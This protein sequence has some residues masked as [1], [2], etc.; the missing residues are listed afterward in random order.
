M[1]GCSSDPAPAS[2]G[3]GSSP[4]SVELLT[5]SATPAGTVVYS[6]GVYLLDGATTNAAQVTADRLVFPASTGAAIAG[7]SAGDILVSSKDGHA[8]FLRRVTSV[9]TSG[10]T[11]V[12]FTQDARI[13]DAVREAHLHFVLTAPGGPSARSSPAIS[14]ASGPTGG[15]FGGKIDFAFAEGWDC[16]P[17]N[18]QTSAGMRI[19]P[20]ILG[21]YFTPDVTVDASIDIFD[22]KVDIVRFVTTASLDADLKLGLKI[23]DKGSFRLQGTLLET[24]EIPIPIGDI[25]TFVQG[26]IVVGSE[27][28]FYAPVVELQLE[29][30]FTASLTAGFELDKDLSVH[31][32]F[33]STGFNPTF[34]ASFV[35]TGAEVKARR[36]LAAQVSWMAGIPAGV[37]E[38]GP[39]VTV[40]KYWQTRWYADSM[41]GFFQEDDTGHDVTVSGQAKE[42]GATQSLSLKLADFTDSS[43]TTQ[44]TGPFA[45]FPCASATDGD[46]CGTESIDGFRLGVSGHLYTCSG[47]SVAAD[48]AC[49]YG[50]GPAT[51]VDKV[52]GKR[53]ACNPSPT[54]PCHSAADGNYCG[55][56]NLNGFD[57]GTLGLSAAALVTC[58]GGNVSHEQTCS[59]GCG[60]ASGDARVGCLTP[61]HG[62][63]APCGAGDQAGPNNGTCGPDGR[64]YY[65]YQGVWYVKDDC[66]AKSES[67][68]V[69]P[70]GVADVCVSSG[71]T[72]LHGPSA[73]C[74]AG[75]QAGPNNGTCGPDGRVYY[76]YQGV[77]HVKDDCVAKSESCVV[78]P[79]GV[80]DICQASS[81]R[82]RPPTAPCGAGD[83]AGPNNGTCGSD[84]RVYYCYQGTWNLKDDCIARGVACVV[85]PAG[86]ADKCTSGCAA[87]SDCGRGEACSGGRCICPGP[88][89]G[90]S[91]CGAD[92][93]CGSGSRC[94]TGCGMGCPC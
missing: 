17:F 38:V 60:A 21:G 48:T 47:G 37:L 36:Y 86:V 59:G 69:Q 10:S 67:C 45:V 82:L 25:P 18:C 12:V 44:F 85:E 14:P 26:A 41:T 56:E 1:P 29:G 80:A 2:N 35:G 42:L 43:Q 39:V 90:T 54:N 40:R 33:S 68:Q 77:W 3:P 19:T 50:C 61:Q 75:D 72:P 57:G 79:A 23:E 6:P 74:G 84:G 92:A 65:C 93:W 51:G 58:A 66:V 32:I 20:R 73:P 88:V 89:C 27:G 7:R 31:G 34:H 71:G 55:N 46:Y 81:S 70:P 52:R 91:C 49:A 78:E 9:T 13:V 30:G 11:V 4:A 8:S 28:E 24:P 87:S 64:V 83:Q 62:P 5:T 53:V 15:I 16:G 94:C 22:N 63:S 76:C